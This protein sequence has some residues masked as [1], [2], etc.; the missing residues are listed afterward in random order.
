[1]GAVRDKL[2][3]PDVFLAYRMISGADAEASSVAKN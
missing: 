2:D 1:M 3:Y